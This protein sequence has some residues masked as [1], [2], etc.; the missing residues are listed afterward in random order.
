M[1]IHAPRGHTPA[2]ALPV[3]QGAP[4]FGMT[5][6]RPI[7]P[8]DPW[9]G[10]LRVVMLLWGGVLLGAFA[11]PLSTDPMVFHWDIISDLPGNTKV[12]PMLL[13]AIGVLGILLAVIPMV[14]LPRGILATVLGLAGIVVP[15][16]LKGLPEWRSLLSQ[17]GLLCLVPGLLVRQEYTDSLVARILVT[18]GV[19]CTLAP[20]LVPNQGEIPLVVLFKELLH[21]SDKTKALAVVELAI[22]ISVLMSLLAGM[23]GPSTAGAKIFAWVVLSCSFFTLVTIRLIDGHVVEAVKASPFRAL[24]IWAPTTAYEVLAGYGVATVIGKQ[25]E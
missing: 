24:M 22:L 19:A 1:G 10:A 6:G 5:P 16:A 3:A 12:E 21:A 7:V 23:P 20:L 4:Y 9:R 25:L 17:V 13:A 2:V 8:I 18:I 15:I 14:T 11:T